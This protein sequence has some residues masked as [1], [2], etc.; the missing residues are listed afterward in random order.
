LKLLISFY[1]K[2][3]RASMKIQVAVALF[4]HQADPMKLGAYGRVIQRA[5]LEKRAP[6]TIFLTGMTFDAISYHHPLIKSAIRDGNVFPESAGAFNPH[7]PEIGISCA[8]YL[9]VVPLSLELPYWEHHN[10]MAFE[11]IKW[12]KKNLWYNFGKNSRGFFPPEM[13][14]APAGAQAIKDNW[15]SYVIFDGMHLNGW[16]RGQVFDVEG[17]KFLPRTPDF[18]FGDY[19][20]PQDVVGHVKWLAHAHGISRVI[21]GSDI[22]P[23][24]HGRMSEYG[25]IKFLWQLA[26][27]FYEDPST[28]LVNAA[29]IADNYWHP[30]DLRD[31]YRDKGIWD[32]HHWTSSWVNSSGVLGFLGDGRSQEVNDRLND[33]TRYF[34]HLG[35]RLGAVEH[36]LKTWRSYDNLWSWYNSLRGWLERAKHDWYSCAGMEFRHPGW[37]SQGWFWNHFWGTHGHAMGELG[38]IDTSLRGL[39][40][41]AFD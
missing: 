38:K 25:W 10:G 12:S 13:V 26:D 24:D 31:V 17:L 18:Y 30:R 1:D 36:Q 16:E 9:P 7:V 32:P 33:F 4:G 23:Y 5:V 15:C 21:I 2:D 27:A 20:N 6:F 29:S 8:K 39:E 22:D 40:R 34:A 14:I 37:I 28:E 19:S 41:H 35:W 3:V 11:Q